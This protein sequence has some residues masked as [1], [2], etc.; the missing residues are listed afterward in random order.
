MRSS[1]TKSSSMYLNTGEPEHK[2]EI[3]EILDKGGHRALPRRDCLHADERV[4]L[5]A[6]PRRFDYAKRGNGIVD[7]DGHRAAA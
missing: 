4:V 5:G 3:L 1:V 7:L 2:C 6:R